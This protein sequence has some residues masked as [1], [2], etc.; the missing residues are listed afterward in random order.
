MKV[1]KIF[2]LKWGHKFVKKIKQYTEKK[3]KRK[4]TTRS[5]IFHSCDSECHSCLTVTLSAT[6]AWLWHWVP[7]LLGCDIECHSCLTVTLSAT[8]AWL[9]H[10]VPQLLGCDIECHS[11]LTVTLS[12]TVAWLWHWVPQLLGC[13]IEC[14]SSLPKEGQVTVKEFKDNR[15]QN[16][17]LFIKEKIP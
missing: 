13:D 14:H 7:Q 5:D 16:A 10:W 12:A 1:I 15:T 17:I 4:W 6:V 2:M 8:V 9:W 11:C 3:T